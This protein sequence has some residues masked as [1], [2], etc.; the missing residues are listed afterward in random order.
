[1]LDEGLHH[2]DGGFNIEIENII[3]SIKNNFTYEFWV[4]PTEEHD[5]FSQS[6]KG[7]KGLYNQRFVIF[8]GHPGNDHNS[9]LGVSVGTNGVTVFEH[10]H[11][12]FPPTL[13][14]STKINGWTHISIVIKNKVPYLYLN[15]KFIKQGYRSNKENVYASGIIGGNRSYGFFVGNIKNLRI[16]NH[17]RSDDQIRKNFNK[18]HIFE[19]PYLQWTGSNNN[20]IIKDNITVQVNSTKKI[21]QSKS[22]SPKLIAFLLPQYHEIPENNLWWG[23]GFTEWTNTKKAS[24]LFPGHYQP[25]QPF[26]DF[27]YDL[28]DPLVRE[29]QADLAKKHGIFG[30][31]YYHYWFKG[32]RLL[33][34]PFNDVL[35]SGKPNFPFCL[36]WANEPW[37]RRWDGRNDLVLMP[38]DYGDKRDW[39]EHFNYLFKAFIDKRYIRIDDKPLFLIYRPESIPN[40]TEMLAFW[41]A[42]AKKNG[43]K[44]IYF[45][46]TL[47]G[48]PPHYKIE[49]FQCAVEFEPHYTISKGKC[50][51]YWK[52][53]RGYEK[54]LHIM[55]Y[56]AVWSCILNNN[57]NYE[58][59]KVFPGAFVDWDNTARRGK[60]G[61][62]YHGSTPEK[63]EK[64]LS[65]QIK[66]AQENY[67]S[68]FLFINAWNEWAEGTYLEPDKKFKFSYLQAVQKSLKNNN[69][70][71]NF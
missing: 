64:Y 14:H 50:R 27:Y 5:L 69:I 23:K 21:N 42:L 41:E 19:N 62:I 12:F 20:Q 47:N 29:W 13:V 45:V 67:Y 1:M 25:R 36:S 53:V 59:D 9:G 11:Y 30:F 71:Y 58:Y 2:F 66:K 70:D 57:N 4:K 46:Q 7:I 22:G 26:N 18:D 28:T 48:F 63:F 44:G 49:G 33:E 40:C 51:N 39:E 55:D 32:E 31:C 35:E 37:T 43:L 6:R 24:P 61:S 56:D 34:K 15:G 17:S 8:P 60:E 38:Q 54:N 3:K 68:E 10:S 65:L 52:K 16:W